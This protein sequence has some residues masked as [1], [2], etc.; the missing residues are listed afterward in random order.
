MPALRTVRVPGAGHL[1]HLD[2][3]GRFV[4]EICA[5]TES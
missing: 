2:N 4:E 1:V 5:A 3:P